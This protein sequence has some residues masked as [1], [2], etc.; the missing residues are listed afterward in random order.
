MGLMEGVL[1]INPVPMQH[2]Y[3]LVGAGVPA[4]GGSNGVNSHVA[5]LYTVSWWQDYHCAV[6]HR[7][8][9]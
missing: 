8:R 1:L 4:G 3:L 5:L 7:Y 9:I 2:T 6:P